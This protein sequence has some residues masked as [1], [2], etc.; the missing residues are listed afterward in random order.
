MFPLMIIETTETRFQNGRPK[1]RHIF[2]LNG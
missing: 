2:Y 1:W